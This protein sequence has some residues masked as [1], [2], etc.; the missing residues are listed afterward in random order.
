MRLRNIFTNNIKVDN[1]Y[2]ATHG[3]VFQVFCKSI[4]D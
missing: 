1:L 3:V 4:S 2:G